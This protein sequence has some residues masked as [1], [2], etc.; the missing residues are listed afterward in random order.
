VREIPSRLRLAAFFRQHTE[1]IRIC[2]YT[3][4]IRFPFACLQT[5]VTSFF[6]HLDRILCFSELFLSDKLASNTLAHLEKG[7]LA[8]ERHFCQNSVFSMVSDY[9]LAGT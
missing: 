7:T 6:T 9:I 2:L 1:I 8:S 5:V 3:D 4:Y